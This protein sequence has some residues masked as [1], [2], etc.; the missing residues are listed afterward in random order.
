MA[1]APVVV[2]SLRERSRS[3]VT[4]TEHTKFDV[5]FTPILSPGGRQF[6]SIHPMPSE[7]ARA[8]SVLLIQGVCNVL[9]ALVTF[10]Q[11]GLTL[12]ALVILWGAYAIIDGAMAFSAGIAARRTGDHSWSLVIAGVVGL[13]AGITAWL[14]PGVTL[15][16][17]LSIVAV[18]AILRGVFVL[19][20]ALMLRHALA[21][22]WLLALSGAVSVAFGV[23]LLVQPAVS[24]VAAVYLIGSV[25]LVF[26]TA[27]IALALHL[28]ASLL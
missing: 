7:I 22:G 1:R 28:R 12:L 27:A 18:W 21:R 11:P 16:A 23:L 6:S 10:V 5:R 9:V 4:L 25:S 3:G 26:G 14:W 8:W 20:A 19:A 17:L 24:L 2:D 15:A 13:V